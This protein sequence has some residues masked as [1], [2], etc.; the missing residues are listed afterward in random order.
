MSLCAA[1]EAAWQACAYAG[2]GA[3][4]YAD[5]EM[6][7]GPVTPHRFLLAA[8]TLVPRPTLPAELRTLAP[9]VIRDSWAAL[10]PRDLPGW[11]PEPDDPWMIRPPGPITVPPVPDVTIEP[12]DDALRFEE[13]AF[14]NAGGA[15]PRRA[16]ELHPAGSH[17]Y[18]G[19]TLFLAQREG[20]PI[21]TALAFQHANGVVVSAV[22]VLADERGNGIGA[23]LTAAAVRRAPHLPA[24]LT[25]SA[26]GN[27]LYERLGFRRLARPRHWHPPGVSRGSLT[28]PPP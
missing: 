18:P 6:A 3:A 13:A 19:L 16:G 8:V 15:P 11:S 25:A 7:W 24:T 17:T 28:E 4:W 23:A 21:G 9:G 2:L 27:N 5:A 26:L 22:A 10:G 20:R 12:T 14:L 1:G